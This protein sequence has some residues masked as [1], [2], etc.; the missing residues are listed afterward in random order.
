MSVLRYAGIMSRQKLNIGV[1]SMYANRQYQKDIITYINE[2]ALN[3][4]AEAFHD[5]RYPDTYDANI[6]IHDCNHSL[7]VSLESMSVYNRPSIALYYSDH[8]NILSQ[9]ARMVNREVCFD[10]S[11]HVIAEILGLNAINTYNNITKADIID[12]DIYDNIIYNINTIINNN[13]NNIGN[14]VLDNDKLISDIYILINNKICP[15]DMITKQS[16]MNSIGVTY[17]IYKSIAIIND[18]RNIASLFDIKITNEE[19]KRKCNDIDAL[20]T[21]IYITNTTYPEILNVLLDHDIIDGT[22]IT[23]TG[24]TIGENI[25]LL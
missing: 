13:I 4:D 14:N 6:Y 1:N 16:I 22:P 3:Y 20:K 25:K 21:Q 18:I 7:Q 12:L 17:M 23:I 9:Y 15:R 24:K 2:N 5:G 8:T 19:I 11:S 10:N